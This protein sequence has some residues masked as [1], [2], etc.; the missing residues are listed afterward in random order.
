LISCS[1]RSPL[2]TLSILL[3][4]AGAMNPGKGAFVPI[5]AGL[6]R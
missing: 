6:V 5:A 2:S 1:Q 3:A 4:S